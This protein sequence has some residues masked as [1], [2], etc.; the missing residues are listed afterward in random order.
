MPHKDTMKQTSADDD[1]IIAAASSCPALDCGSLVIDYRSADNSRL[2]HPEDRDFTCSRCGLDFTVP[3]DELIFRS[4]PKQWFS[5][6]TL[7]G[8]RLV[9]DSQTTQTSSLEDFNGI[10]ST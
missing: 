9:F 5:A 4:I 7:R 6:A 3:L 2:G 10:L 8:I 1:D